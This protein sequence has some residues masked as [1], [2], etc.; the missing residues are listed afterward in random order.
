MSSTTVLLTLQVLKPTMPL[1][2]L[3]GDSDTG[4]SLA[5]SSTEGTC[6]FWEQARLVGC[7][8]LV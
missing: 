8:T 4:E 6:T 7:L 2:D 1:H 3:P 5:K